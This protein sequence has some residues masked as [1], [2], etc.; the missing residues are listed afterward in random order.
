VTSPLVPR[1]VAALV[2]LLGPL[3]SGCTSEAAS[4]GAVSASTSPSPAAAG[5]SSAAELESL[6]VDEVPSGLPLVPDAELDPPAGEKTI[7]DVARY[8]QDADEQRA[9]LEDYGYLRGWERFWRSGNAL[10][11]VFVDQFEG[12]EGAGAYA[13][14]LARNDAEYYGGALD[15]SPGDLPEGCVRMVRDFPAPER[16]IAGPAAF[17]WCASGVFT[18][19]VAAVAANPADARAELIAVTAD[20]LG[21]LPAG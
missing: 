7:D 2:L 20:Q 19:A 10:T 16:G 17:A 11:S 12:Q 9:V 8:G 4:P 1:A 13:E 15:H 18:V 5:P 14:D 6:V 21:R 3:V